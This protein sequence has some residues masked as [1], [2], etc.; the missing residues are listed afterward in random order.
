MVDNLL[1]S[2][3]KRAYILSENIVIKSRESYAFGSD[4]HLD[5]INKT[6]KV[7]NNLINAL[8]KANDSIEETFPSDIESA[9]NLKVQIHALQSSLD[10]TIKWI[11]NNPHF[12]NC[13]TDCVNRLEIECDQIREFIEDLND[14]VI[15][16]NRL[17]PDNFFDNL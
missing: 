7:F 17:V 4:A 15:S 14:Y 5:E 8:S 13:Y 12:T 16:N 6:T 9:L 11:R 1:N 2:K 10:E 3:V